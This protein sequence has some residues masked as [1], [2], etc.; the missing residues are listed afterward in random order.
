MKKMEGR[1]GKSVRI[2]LVP[3]LVGIMVALLAT[4]PCRGAPETAPTGKS[5]DQIFKEA[6]E[7]AKTNPA[8]SL[9]AFF[10]L[11][12]KG[13]SAPELEQE[14]ERLS[15]QAI[16]ADGM[17]LFPP[18]GWEKKG[19]FLVNRGGSERVSFATS[20]SGDP[21]GLSRKAV[22]DALPP[23]RFSDEN[24]KEYEKLRKMA[25]EIRQAAPDV[26]EGMK[27]SALPVLESKAARGKVDGTMTLASTSGVTVPGTQTACALAFRSGEKTSVLTWAAVGE[28]PAKGEEVLMKLLNVIV[29]A[30]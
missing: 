3:L 10:D 2:S 22:I 30:P 5:P 25:E 12:K 7:R 20:P 11:R 27:V 16:R 21:G 19:D 14:I 17:Y 13:F 26:A 24:L 15:G 6:A 23:G 9:R 4:S 28:S 8:D 18:A 29:V 1:S